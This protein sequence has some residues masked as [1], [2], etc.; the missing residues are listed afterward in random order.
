MSIPIL[1][2]IPDPLLTVSCPPHVHN[3]RTVRGLM[4]NTLLALVPAVVM[5]AAT[6][7]LPAVRVMALSMSSAVVFEWIGWRMMGRPSQADDYS[8]LL[9]GLLFAFLL[10]ATAPWWLVVVGSGL[11]IMLGKM[12]FGGL[13]GAPLCAP[14]LG[15]AICNISWP[16]YMDTNLSLLAFNLPAPIFDLMHFGPG[17]V[18]DLNPVELLLGRQLGGLGAA[19]PAALALGGLYLL[20]RKRVRWQVPFAFLLGVTVGA[21]VFQATGDTAGPLVHLLGGSTVFA[22]FFLATDPSSSPSGRLPMFL[23]GLTGGFLLVLIR[24]YGVY[25]EAAPFAVLL[26]NL[27]APLLD[28]IRPRP[29]GLPPRGQVEKGG[30]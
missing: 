15:W 14:A 19:Q 22:A 4:L 21:L 20:F 11:T 18:A 24:V 28:R 16:G 10:P 13:G 9:T 3:G 7:G 29:F 17:A 5:A 25:A 8:A 1:P 30:A 6:F 26:A 12:I 2:R 23:Y 27:L